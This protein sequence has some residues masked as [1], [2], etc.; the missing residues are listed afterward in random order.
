VCWRL[1]NFGAGAGG[2]VESI[3]FLSEHLYRV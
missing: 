1:I 2:R 3:H